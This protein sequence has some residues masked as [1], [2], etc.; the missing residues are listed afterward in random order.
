MAHRP[1]HQRVE[2]RTHGVFISWS[3]SGQLAALLQRE[4]EFGFCL[5]LGEA[6]STVCD[7]SNCRKTFRE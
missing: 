2:S 1:Q 4:R 7:F 5:W 6:H 3:L